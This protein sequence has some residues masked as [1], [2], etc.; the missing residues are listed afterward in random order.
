MTKI[1]IPE[2]MHKRCIN[3]TLDKKRVFNIS[4]IAFHQK[5]EKEKKLSAAHICACVKESDRENPAASIINQICQ[6]KS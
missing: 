3:L 6:A 5:G 1:N 4:S 2:D